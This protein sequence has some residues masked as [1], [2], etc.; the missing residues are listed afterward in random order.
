MIHNSK[1]LLLTAVVTFSF[2]VIFAAAPVMTAGTNKVMA[3]SF[4]SDACSGLSQA[5]GTGCGSN[6]GSSISDLMTNIINLLSIAVGF[7]AVVMI[8]I[9]GI[10]FITAQGEASGIASARSALIY[11]LVG[12]VIAAMAQIIVHF[13]F[14]KVT[15]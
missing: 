8:I 4:Q 15:K 11:A 3:A 1:Y 7:A 13:V 2:G 14:G 9:S 10:R 5:G 12:L 6:P